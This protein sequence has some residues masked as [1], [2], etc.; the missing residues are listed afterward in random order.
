MVPK[1]PF[2][3][4]SLITRYKQDNL[5]FEREKGNA[6]R[7]TK[8]LIVDGKIKVIEVTPEEYFSHIKS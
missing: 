1:E 7:F 8:N 2:R 3:L 5:Y 6:S 4:L